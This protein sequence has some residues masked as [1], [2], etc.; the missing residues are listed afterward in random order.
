VRS[1][2]IPLFVSLPAVRRDTRPATARE[3]TLAFVLVLAVGLLNFHAEIFDEYRWN[4]TIELQWSSVGW[5]IVARK[6]APRLAF[7][8]TLIWKPAG[9]ITLAHPVLIKK[10]PKR[11]DSGEYF[12]GAIISR[13]YRDDHGRVES[14]QLAELIDC[15][16]KSVATAGDL[17]ENKR[18]QV[19]QA[20][21][22]PLPGHWHP[23]PPEI[24]RYFCAKK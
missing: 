15:S 19:L 9:M 4:K 6:S 14:S 12:I 11:D 21:G 16:A 1:I 18:F 17:K 3:T 5:E 7:P 22:A 10:V 2:A 13:F 24:H 20:N 8:W 23:A